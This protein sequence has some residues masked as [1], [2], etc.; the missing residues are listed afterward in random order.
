MSSSEP[1]AKR[2]CLAWSGGKDCCLALHRTASTGAIP[3]RLLTMLTEEGDRTRSHGLRKE[4][5]EEQARALGLPLRCA[6]ASWERYEEAFIGLL[7]EAAQEGIRDV[8]FGDIDIP[9][10]RQWEERVAR[11][12][13]MS[14][15]LPLWKQDRQCLLEEAWELGIRARIVVVRDKVLGRRFLGRD[16]DPAT[17]HE[18]AEEGVDLCGENGEFHT[19]VIDGPDFAHPLTISL[20]RRVLK[21]GC[22]A[23]DLTLT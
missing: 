14:A 22:W 16:L 11:I 5:V 8:V 23:Q 6:A 18:L 7:R 20:G 2:F 12:A 9:R 4:I 19:V 1:H 21:G 3:A 10:H 17:V 13:G 15:H